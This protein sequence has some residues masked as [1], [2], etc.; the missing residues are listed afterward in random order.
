MGNNTHIAFHSACWSEYVQVMAIN[1]NDMKCDTPQ[2]V[3]MKKD[4]LSE[5]NKF[6]NPGWITNDY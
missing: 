5:K 2:P 3:S 1:S 4:F 6:E